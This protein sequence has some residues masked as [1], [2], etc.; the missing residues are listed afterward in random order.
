MSSLIEL[1]DDVL[2]NMIKFVAPPDIF[3][4]RKTCK[5]LRAFTLDRHIWTA[6]YKCSEDKFM[7]PVVLD[8]QTVSNLE[9]ALL[10][11]Y[12]LNTLWT[13]PSAKP[14][15][16]HVWSI[17]SAASRGSFDGMAIYQSRYLVGWNLEQI[18]VFDLQ[19][20]QKVFAY[21]APQ[22]EYFRFLD[23]A[24]DW[25][26]IVDNRLLLSILDFG[27]SGGAVIAQDQSVRGCLC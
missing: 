15:C 5:R 9:R 25:S 4:V 20:M 13:T 21:N 1:P 16:K 23:S 2:L 27:H 12:Q 8:S 10:R 17:D 26:G 24:L 7:P 19:T 6:A 18:V 14:V 22:D 3:S 11:S